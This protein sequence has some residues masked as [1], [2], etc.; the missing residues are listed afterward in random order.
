MSGETRFD[1]VH[2]EATPTAAIDERRAAPLEL[3]DQ[4][5]IIELSIR[6][7]LW[8]VPI[9]SARASALI[10]AVAVAMSLVVRGGPQFVSLASICSGEGFA[11]LRPATT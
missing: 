2:V 6:P 8:F 10:V 11:S 4:D 9:V 3:L 5:E 7:S 1:A